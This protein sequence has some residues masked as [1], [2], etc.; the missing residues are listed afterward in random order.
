[1][2][3]NHSDTGQLLWEQQGYFADPSPPALSLND[4]WP[5]PPPA[6]DIA[7]AWA[8]G[9]EELI[10][11]TSR[12]GIPLYLKFSP[13]PFADTSSATQNS[14]LV[15]WVNKT[16]VAYPTAMRVNRPIFLSYPAGLFTNELHLT[17]D[18]A[19]SFSNHL[20]DELMSHE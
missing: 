20:A 2:F 11:F 18:G 12:Q 16:D 1:M 19:K 6:W 17:P 15:N 8:E 7:P 9:L 10:Q 3:P 5:G 4:N 14:P 13:V